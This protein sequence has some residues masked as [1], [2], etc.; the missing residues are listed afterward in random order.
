MTEVLRRVRIERGLTQ[1][2]VGAA[3]GVRQ[4]EIS[5]WENGRKRPNLRSLIAWAGALGM[6]LTVE[7]KPA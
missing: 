7:K 2:N 6:R 3:S 5:M 4:Q 1:E